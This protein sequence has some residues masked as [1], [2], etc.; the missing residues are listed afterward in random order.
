MKMKR[1]KKRNDEGLSCFMTMNEIICLMLLLT[2]PQIEL[3]CLNENFHMHYWIFFTYNIDINEH[4]GDYKLGSHFSQ[5]QM[6]NVFPQV[7]GEG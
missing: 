3:R 5:P 4:I 6:K 7:F 1:Q 2:E